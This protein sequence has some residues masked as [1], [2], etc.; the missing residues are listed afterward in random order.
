MDVVDYYDFPRAFTCSD[1]SGQR[2]FAMWRDENKWLVV[3]VSEARE[4]AFLRGEIGFREMFT[5]SESGECL[6]IDASWQDLGESSVLNRFSSIDLV[7]DEDGPL[8]PADD[9]VPQPFQPH[10][11]RT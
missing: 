7:G 9:F 10:P 4:A 8:P 11:W 1:A 2:Y 3:A 6:W 5:E